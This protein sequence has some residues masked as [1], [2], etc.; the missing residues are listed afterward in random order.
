MATVGFQV[1]GLLVPV[2]NASCVLVADPT[3]LD[4]GIEN[5]TPNPG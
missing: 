3:T 5:C 4:A 2:V 1:V